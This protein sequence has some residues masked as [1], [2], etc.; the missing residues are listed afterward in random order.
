MF[1]F[2]IS[3]SNKKVHGVGG[4]SQ[5]S[6]FFFKLLARA[7]LQIQEN[8]K[9]PKDFHQFSLILRIKTS[10]RNKWFQRFLYEKLKTNWPQV[11]AELETKTIV[12]PIN[13]L[14]FSFIL[15]L[16]FFFCFQIISSKSHG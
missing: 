9:I 15:P 11:Q 2:K 5:S 12:S 1:K 16:I 3:C 10:H 8:V 14:F 7:K 4:L 13:S 6:A